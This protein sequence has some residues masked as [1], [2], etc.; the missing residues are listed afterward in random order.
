M[1]VIS[2]SRRGDALV[3]G[4]TG[5]SLILAS[6]MVWVQVPVARLRGV[7]A[8]GSITAVM[9]ILVV[10]VAI[11]A[12]QEPAKVLR[13]VAIVAFSISAYVSVATAITWSVD[14][15]RLDH[16][17]PGLP[18]AVLASVVGMALAASWVQVER[19]DFEGELQTSI[20]SMEIV[21]RRTGWWAGASVL[22]LGLFVAWQV[23]SA[24]VGNAPIGGYGDFSD[25]A[26]GDVD[27]DRVA[28]LVV[29]CVNDQGF[30]VT[31]SFD[32]PGV[33]FGEVPSEQSAAAEQTVDRCEAG[34]NLP[35]FPLESG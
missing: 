22:G 33:F 30:P 11:A 3:I 28:V 16:V 8:A 34:L 25:I 2:G 15:L 35:E 21:P 24:V 19:A 1:R 23:F 13:W 20:D 10:L 17:G 32:G 12:L 9:G 27:W 26:Y 6:F 31:L 18:L 29:E 7:Q 5:S 4:M 14:G